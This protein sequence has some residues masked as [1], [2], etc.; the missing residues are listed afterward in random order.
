MFPKYFEFISSMAGG[1]SFTGYFSFYYQVKGQLYVL[2]Y[3]LR[4]L[5]NT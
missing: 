3:V 4:Q 2:L 1:F 5:V